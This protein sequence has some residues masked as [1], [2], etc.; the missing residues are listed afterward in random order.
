MCDLSGPF[1][2]CTCDTDIDYDQPHWS[3]SM[4]LV[5]RKD[6]FEIQGTMA[7]PFD[8]APTL[9]DKLE[10]ELNN[11]DVFDFDYSPQ[12]DDSLT[13][14]YD[15]DTSDTFDFVEGK[16]RQKG[17]LGQHTWDTFEKELQGHLPT[18]K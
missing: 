13:F 1:K 8:K 9:A 15:E 12:E 18:K 14:Q 11:R 2:L 10:I 4:N 5:D 16:W 17:S 3:L 6:A 7:Y